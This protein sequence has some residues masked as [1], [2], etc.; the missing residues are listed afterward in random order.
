MSGNENVAFPGIAD[1]LDD[2]GGSDSSGGSSG[3]TDSDSGGDS[4]DSSD[5]GG[6]GSSTDFGE[7]LGAGQR[8]SGSDSGGGD[9]PAENDA[10]EERSDDSEGGG[11]AD[12]SPSVGGS[13]GGI[14]GGVVDDSRPE[15]TDS[16]DGFEAERLADQ[17]TDSGSGDLQDRVTAA[18]AARNNAADELD[19]DPA[20]VEVDLDQS[21]DGFS[22][23]ARIDTEARADTV[24]A[25]DDRL[26]ENDVSTQDGQVGLTEQGKVS[27]AAAQSDRFN[28]SDL[29]V[30][31][32][33]VTLTDS[34]RDSQQRTVDAGQVSTIDMGTDQADEIAAANEQATQQNTQQDSGEPAVTAGLDVTQDEIG[35]GSGGQ[36]T[37]TSPAPEGASPVEATIDAVNEFQANV[38]D[39]LSPADLTGDTESQGDGADTTVTALPAEL[40]QQLES[41]VNA[42]LGAED[43][44]VER[45]TNE[46]GE[47]VISAELTDQ[48]RDTIA[49]QNAAFSETP[50]IGDIT[51][52][53]A[54]LSGRFQRDVVEPS[55]DVAGGVTADVIE[56][57]TPGVDTSDLAENVRP[58]DGD[59]NVLEESFTGTGEG[60][61][62]LGSA[63]IGSPN[64][65][66][67]IGETGSEAVEFAVRNP[68]E[69]P[70]ATVAAG[71][72]AA[73]NAIQ[74]GRENPGMVTG[75]L[76]GSSLLFRGAR[77]VGPRTS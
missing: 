42:D 3:S 66:A 55:A 53:S 30:R 50:V 33:Q 29:T 64:T 59:E 75:S 49:R 17:Q 76:V 37:A 46:D 2:S 58:A 56:T 73:E 35:P 10:E 8:T 44:S 48:G 5:G 65:I 16:G 63:V 36:E 71:Q 77:A 25:Q 15:T 6:G 34:V 74:L 41:D 1:R 45:T 12:A 54:V 40:E 51:G 68:R 21:G 20:D 27:L 24:V 13:S 22:A 19:V 4:G 7:E 39:G 52:T 26:S 9:S 31:N 72:Q 14:G 60:V 69:V 70:D 47:T 28:E 11:Q 57:A 62:A 32:G 67:G 23:T 43:V 61:G 38:A 18:A